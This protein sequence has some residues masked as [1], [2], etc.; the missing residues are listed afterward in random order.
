VDPLLAVVWYAVLLFSLTFHEAAHGLAA[1]R[2]GDPT[3]YRLG[4]VSLDPRPHIRREPLGTVFVPLFSFAISGWMIGWASTPYDPR[5]ADRHPRRAAWMSL[6]GPAANLALVVA[7]G[8]AIR[9]LILADVLEAPQTITFTQVAVGTAGGI[10]S[11]LAI[12]LSVLFTLNLLLTVF[13]LIPVPPLDGAGALGLLLGEEHSRRLRL[14]LAQP[15]VALL[16]ILV[17]W[18]LIGEVFWP[19]HLLAIRLLYP[20]LSYG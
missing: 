6:A 19:V 16:G 9:I 2:G 7:A 15:Q 10:G 8:V 5:W 14:L 13:N 11:T 20:E 12:F 4:Q 3:A 17:A 1:R 18:Y